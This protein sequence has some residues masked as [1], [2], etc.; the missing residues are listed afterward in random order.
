MEE[1]YLQFSFYNEW[2]SN[3]RKK[4]NPNYK[5]HWFAL[6]ERIRFEPWYYELSWA[7]LGIFI[8]LA[9]LSLATCNRISMSKKALKASCSQHGGISVKKTINKFIELG[10]FFPAKSSRPNKQNKTIQPANKLDGQMDIRPAVQAAINRAKTAAP[11]AS[12]LPSGAL[13]AKMK[14]GM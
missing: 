2:T 12:A 14:Q 10:I 3:S 7:E 9:M 4:T 13:A 1:E 11:L 5:P 8:H 6:S